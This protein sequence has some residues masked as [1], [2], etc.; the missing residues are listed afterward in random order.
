MQHRKN[1][2]LE[3]NTGAKS[4]PV[5]IRQLL[6]NLVKNGKI[7]TTVKRAEVLK[8][9]ADSF[10]GR[11]VANTAK[12]EE[13]DARRENIR[14]IKS[15]I[16]SEPEGKKVLETLVPKYVENG[17]K[18]GFVASYKLG[19]RVGDGAEKILLKLI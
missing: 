2:L 17:L 10:F 19:Y 1:R 13:K 14:Y 18:S 3:I 9:Y 5:F 15:E 8:A 4:K 16:F 11:L 12:Y 7:T 6:T